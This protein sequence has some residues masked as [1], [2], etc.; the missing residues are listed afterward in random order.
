MLEVLAGSLAG[1]AA[2]GVFGL[3][4][5]RRRR[6]MRRHPSPTFVFADLVGYTAL[7]EARG[8]E[9]AAK[10]ARE[11]RRTMCDLSRSH[12]ATQVKSMGD[13]VMIWAPDP[14]AAMSLASHA[15]EEVGARSD[16][17]PVRVGVHTGPAVMQG[18]DWYGT[19]VNVAARLAA[20][21]EPNEALVS[22]ATRAAAGS[23]LPAALR[24]RGEVSLRGLSRPVV[25]WRLG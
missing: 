18:C 20:Q 14:G 11:F 23:R 6:A 2:I 9:A 5:T 22:A 19:S 3:V 8:D 21:A 4:A 10:L 1:A 25:A 24:E 13:G 15:V 16:L 12:G 7:T 17:L